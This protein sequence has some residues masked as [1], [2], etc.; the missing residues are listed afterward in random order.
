[1]KMKLRLLVALLLLPSAIAYAGAIR[2]LPGFATTVYGPNDDGTYPVTGSNQGTP[3]GAPALVPIGFSVNF[4][5]QTFTNLYVNNNGNITFD[6]PLG[7]FTPFGLVGTARQVIAPFFADVDTRV[8]NLVTFGN[9]TVDGHAAFGVNWIGV[10]YFDSEA[11]KL[12]SFQLVLIDR[13]D[14]NPGDFDIEF[15]YDQIQWE[16]GD[17]S[18]GTDGLGG[19]SAVAGF[20]NGSKRPGTSYQLSGS[21]IPRSFLDINPGGLIHN[22]LNTN[23]PGRYV[24]PIVNL[25]DKVLNVPRFAQADPQWGANAYAG[26]DSTIAQQGSALACLAMAL[27]YAGIATDP[28]QLNATLS[29][30]NDYIGAGIN[31]GPATR[32]VSSDTLEFHAHR[33]TDTQYL[34][35]ILAMGYPVIVEVANSQ[36]G[37]HYVLVTGYKNG[38]FL[39]NDPGQANDTTLDAFNNTFETRGYVS[40]PPGDV[41]EFD[42]ATAN[43]TQ[44]LIVDPLGRRTGYDASARAVVESVPQSVYF[45]DNIESSD[46]TGAPG[47]NTSHIVDIYQPLPGT[48]QIYLFG[49]NAGNYSA[50][51]RTFLADGSPGTSQN[52]QAAL[53]AASYA[54]FQVTFGPGGVTSQ[55]FTNQYVWTADPTNGSLP[56][57]VQFMAPDTD[58]AGNSVTNWYWN[59]GDGSMSTEQDPANTYTNSG[60]FFPSVTAIDDAGNTVVSFGP[61]IIIPTVAYTA[62][63]SYGAGPL[64]VQFNAASVDLT[65]NPVGGWLWDFGDGS[66]DTVQNP[67][68]TYTSYGTFTPILTATDNQG[69]IVYGAGPSV[70]SMPTQIQNGGFETDDLQNWT[71]DGDPFD[72]FVDDGASFSDMGPH[73]GSFFAALGTFLT[74]ASL[75]Q[76]II[77]IPGRTY[78]ISLYFNS[79]DGATNTEFSVKWNGAT[80]FDQLNVPAIGWTNLQFTVTAATTVGTLQFAYDNDLSFFGLDDVSIT[81]VVKPPALT[82]TRAG[83]N[84]VLAW[85]TNDTIFTLR[86]TTDMVSPNWVTNG[87]PVIID[88]QNVVTN[89]ISAGR[90]FFQLVQ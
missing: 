56:L 70:Q 34:S 40:D 39:I 6:S 83:A 62:T 59:F 82:I 74:P 73:S 9:D 37:G 11:D 57:P 80:L 75:S 81:P 26:S 31:W 8:G 88:G 19:S 78:L 49:V 28:G 77:T 30:E 4:Y 32:D 47:T 69:A 21:S 17:A 64:T 84:V 5:G 3:Q 85:P 14:R 55:T 16:T 76:S 7:E 89:P 43:N 65:G 35:Q 20:S 12:N 15:N 41:S 66:T 22:F 2:N 38:Q 48:Y 86:S 53:P 90:M 45:S 71:L 68:H 87:L 18:Q 46:I 60:P 24:I 42:I 67:S 36:G 29:S 52:L 25:T 10:G 63:P 54:A 72:T 23:I 58:T 13:S 27:H 44:L 79:P 1:M 51:L 61:S 33:G 50:S